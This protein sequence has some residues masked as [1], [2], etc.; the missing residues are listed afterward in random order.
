MCVCP[1]IV[2]VSLPG[3]APPLMDAKEDTRLLLDE[4]GGKAGGRVWVGRTWHQNH[5]ALLPSA[6]QPAASASLHLPRVLLSAPHARVSPAP[7]QLHGCG[8]LCVSAAH[9]ECEWDLRVC[10]HARG[11]RSH[12]CPSE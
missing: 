9:H 6:G 2:N 4:L 12:V 1:Q 8:W 3:Q 7:V 10:E 5:Q 11:A